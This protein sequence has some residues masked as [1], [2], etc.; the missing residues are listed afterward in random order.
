MLARLQSGLAHREMGLRDTGD[1]NDVYIAILQSFVDAAVGFR[2]WVVLL[3]IVIGLGGALDYRMDFVDIGK[4]SD[5][6]DVED[7]GTG[8]VLI[9]ERTKTSMDL[10]LT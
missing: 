2:A 9:S 5:Q 4:S 8:E 3:C 1:D 7:F 6:R 10:L